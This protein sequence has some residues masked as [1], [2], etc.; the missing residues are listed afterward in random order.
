MKSQRGL[1][2]L[3]QV[4]ESFRSENILFFP[5]L[6]KTQESTKSEDRLDISRPWVMGFEFSR[7]EFDFSSGRPD[8]DVA[9]NIYRHPERQKQPQRPFSKVHDIYSLG[10][11]LLEIG[12]CITQIVS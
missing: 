1:L 12:K 9:R 7:P 4:H 8:K 11:V 5:R 6:L 3:I 2:T 10:V